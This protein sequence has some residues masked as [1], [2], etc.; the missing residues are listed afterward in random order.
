MQ[1][2]NILFYTDNTALFVREL[3]E[4]KTGNN[5]NIKLKKKQRRRIKKK[6]IKY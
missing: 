2:L 3:F 6:N 1:Q 5:E 4:E